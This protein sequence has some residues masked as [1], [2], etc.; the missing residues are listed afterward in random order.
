MSEPRIKPGQITRPIQLLA[1][2]LAGLLALDGTFLLGAATISS[3][4]WVPSLL[5]IAAVASVPLFLVAIFILQTR[6][7]P[8]MQEDPYYAT[9]LA[10]KGKSLKEQRSRLW[11][12][13]LRGTDLSH[14]RLRTAELYLAEV[15]ERIELNVDEREHLQRAF[16]QALRSKEDHVSHSIQEQIASFIDIVTP[17]TLDAGDRSAMLLSR[18]SQLRYETV[19]N[20]NTGIV[21][22]DITSI[23][24]GTSIEHIRQTLRVSAR[25][26]NKKIEVLPMARPAKVQATLGI[27]ETSLA[28]IVA[29]AILYSPLGSTITIVVAHVG[30]QKIRITVANPIADS[31]VGPLARLF[32][33]G[34]RG[35]RSKDMAPAGMGMGLF[36]ARQSLAIVHGSVDLVA[37]EGRFSANIT[38]ES[39]RD[40]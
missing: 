30:D 31:P 4:A 19:L 18:L 38:L 29:N 8:E 14:E 6:F 1:A 27:F 7:R 33:P 17:A 22:E 10:T 34:L 13:L 3:P 20:A 26:K 39:A 16:R 35:E 40:E 24:V 11:E 32:E 9:Y 23:D 37:S 28:E 15:A 2:W 5:A 21:R 36:L 25:E 12:E